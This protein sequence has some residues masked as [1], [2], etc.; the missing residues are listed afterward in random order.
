M[1]QKHYIP[2]CCGAELLHAFPIPYSAHHE[3]K[4][5]NGMIQ[6]TTAFIKDW[7]RSAVFY[8]GPNRDKKAY[9][10]YTFTLIIL[11]EKQNEHYSKLLEEEGFEL[12]DNQAK[13]RSSVH[14]YLYRFDGRKYANELNGEKDEPSSRVSFV[15]RCKHFA[16]FL[17]GISPHTRQGYNPTCG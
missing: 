14:L 7:K 11:N 12:I 6:T 15:L 16:Q 17:Y 13:S 3:E 5:I 9:P 10:C 8:M 2:S 4:V 1:P